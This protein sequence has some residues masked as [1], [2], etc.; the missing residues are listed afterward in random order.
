MIRRILTTCSTDN[1]TAPWVVLAAQGPPTTNETQIPSVVT[2][3]RPPEH[4]NDWYRAIT[5]ALPASIVF[6]A[7]TWYSAHHGFNRKV[8]SLRSFVHAWAVKIGPHRFDRKVYSLLSVVLSATMAS[9]QGILLA[10]P[11]ARVGGA[12]CCQWK[13]PTCLDS[14]DKWAATPC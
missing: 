5:P 11:G 14:S 13:P 1:S 12:A 6:R 3:Q 7:S 9:L 10:K 2:S 4:R 8:C